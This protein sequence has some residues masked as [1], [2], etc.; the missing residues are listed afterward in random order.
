MG[1]MELNASE[2]F[3][4]LLRRKR[5]CLIWGFAYAILRWTKCTRAHN[6]KKV[7]SQCFSLWKNTFIF[8]V[9]CTTSPKLSGAHAYSMSHGRKDAITA[10]AFKSI[11]L[12]L[13]QNLCGFI[14]IFYTEHRYLNICVI[15]DHAQVFSV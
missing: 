6:L 8:G 13:G 2:W 4:Q 5:A 12:I 14:H 1:L 11:T 9:V 15:K 10:A 3:T 7:K